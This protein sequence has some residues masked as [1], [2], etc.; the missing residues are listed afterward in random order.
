MSYTLDLKIQQFLSENNI[1]TTEPLIPISNSASQRKYYRVISNEKTYILTYSKNIKENE[2][3]LYYTKGFHKIKI[4]TPTIIAV[5][6]DQTIYLQ[7]DLGDRNLLSEIQDHSP[8]VAEY[9]ENAISDIAKM[10]VL[11]PNEINFSQAYEFQ[12][13]DNKLIINDLFYCKNY[14]FEYLE[15]P[16]Q[17]Q[18]LI[19]DFFAIAQKAQ[20]LPHHFFMYRDFQSRN[21]MIYENENYYIDYQGGMQ[22]IACYDCVSF[23]WQA[24]AQ[25]SIPQ[26][27]EIKQRYFQEMQKNCMISLQELEDSYRLSLVI[28]LFQLLGAYGFRGLV[29]GKPHFIE[30]IKYNLH[31]IQYLVENQY[32]KDYPELEK[33]SKNELHPNKIN[34]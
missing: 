4:N 29:Q 20:R 17:K 11:L 12:N 27:E 13:F 21:I 26:K 31:N 9:T 30:S 19:E 8:Y 15:L 3:F 5:S 6:E 10:N 28:R 16:F 22:G 2:C 32:L 33:I 1:E 24:K 14:F 25:F 34:I 23:S 7:N 18:K